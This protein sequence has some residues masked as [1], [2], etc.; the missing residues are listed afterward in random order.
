MMWIITFMFII[1]KKRC[2]LG[3]PEHEYAWFR[4]VRDVLTAEAVVLAVG[5]EVESI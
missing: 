5:P 3:D 4:E 1:L 2:D